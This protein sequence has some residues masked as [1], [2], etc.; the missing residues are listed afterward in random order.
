MLVAKKPVE[1][2]VV[3]AIV[4]KLENAV[5]AVV[6]TVV[7]MIRLTAAPNMSSKATSSTSID[8]DTSNR[9]NYNISL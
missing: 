2:M 6:V 1:Q 4:A 7:V 8:T 3:A 9:I 5:V